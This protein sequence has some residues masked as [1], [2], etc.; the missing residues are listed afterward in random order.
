MALGPIPTPRRPWPRS[1][2]TPKIPTGWRPFSGKGDPPGSPRVRRRLEPSLRRQPDG[3]D[4]AEEQVGLLV[5]EHAPE[6]PQ[7]G[8]PAPVL[9]GA[10]GTL[11]GA[12]RGRG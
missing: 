1:M 11:C 9:A 7:V 6:A 4:A 8:G 10:Q 3:V 5:G 12:P 2:G